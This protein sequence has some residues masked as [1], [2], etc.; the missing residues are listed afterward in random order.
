MEHDSHS[1][2]ESRTL[3]ELGIE[4]SSEEAALA[5]MQKAV[6]Q[7]RQLVVWLEEFEGTLLS[8]GASRNAAPYD[9]QGVWRLV[10]FHDGRLEFKPVI[11]REDLPPVVDPQLEM[12]DLEDTATGTCRN[13]H[14]EAPMLGRSSA[15]LY[16]M[17]DVTYKT[18]VAVVHCNTV[19]SILRSSILTAFSPYPAVYE[20]HAD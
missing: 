10:P 6:E 14:H 5:S 13:C 20:Q 9:F 17:G 1:L 18:E 16:G 2:Y 12:V 3:T 8:G 11:A 15:E 4:L 19:Q 7:K